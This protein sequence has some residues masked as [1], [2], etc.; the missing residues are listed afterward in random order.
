LVE[1]SKIEWTDHT[2]NPWIGCQKVSPGCDHCYAETMMD[3]R[4]HHVEWGPHGDRI[5][6]SLANRRKPLQWARES[7]G[8]RPKVFCASPADI[9]DNKAPAGARDDLWALIRAT[10]GLDWMLLTKRP[11][12][13]I[14]MSP[15]DWGDREKGASYDHG[16]R[17]ERGAQG[18]HCPLP[19]GLRL[20]AGGR[21]EGSEA[22]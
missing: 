6:T 5:R 2:F 1:N 16:R 22:I 17:R 18:A 15:A 3:L 12:N 11:E 9:F 8:A 14:R 7:N 4:Y 20:H 21:R 13:I 19:A 10:R